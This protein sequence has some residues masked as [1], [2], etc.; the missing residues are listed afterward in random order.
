MKKQMIIA[1]I[2]AASAAAFSACS[3]TGGDAVL[4]SN[5]QPAPGPL[6]LSAIDDRDTET[7]FRAAGI[8]TNKDFATAKQIALADARTQLANKVKTK[9]SATVENVTKAKDVNGEN[10]ITTTSRELISKQATDQTLREMQQ[11]T[12]TLHEKNQNGDFV[13]HV[14]LEVPRSVVANAVS[15]AVDNVAESDPALAAVKEQIKQKSITD[16]IDKGL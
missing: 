10:I 12:A 11:Y 2:L 7:H 6:T 13:V 4:T 5:V 9:V 15:S 16:L 8:G 1:G 14:G 3:T